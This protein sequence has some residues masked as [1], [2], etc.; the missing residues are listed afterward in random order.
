MEGLQVINVVYVTITIPTPDWFTATP[1][2]DP[3][4]APSISPKP[5]AMM[6]C[7]GAGDAGSAF[8]IPTPGCDLTADPSAP[9]Q[10]YNSAEC[11]GPDYNSDMSCNISRGAPANT[12]DAGQT[13][14]RRSRVLVAVV[15]AVAVA[16][17]GG[18]GGGSIAH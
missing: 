15:V 16:V 7:Q 10:W 12:V 18:G 5:T 6:N 14:S 13:T 2:V 3:T 11:F 17:C 9:G 1:T 4:A 8:A